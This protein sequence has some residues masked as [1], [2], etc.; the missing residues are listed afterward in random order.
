MS[1]PAIILAAGASRRLGRPK[2]LV[3]FEGETLLARALRLAREAGAAPILAVLGA[4]F[5]AIC[6]SVD[7]ECA[8]P[9]L[10]DQWES[11]L[12]S[13]I[14]AGLNEA[15]TRSS[16]PAGA[17]VMTCDQP[18]LTAQHLAML[19][20]AFRQHNG[21]SIVASLYAGAHGIPAVFPREV[22]AALR[23]LQG[24]K[25]ARGLFTQAPCAVVS[26][27]FEGGGVDIDRP[28]DLARLS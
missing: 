9:V 18:R 27:P 19:L 14:H 26:V 21:K 10:N 3:N 17:L 7:F 15:E 22:F 11:G 16:E 1:V 8:I 12:A 5:A 6:A 2:Q 24:D 25:G 4:N 20:A 23:S 13:S 28:S